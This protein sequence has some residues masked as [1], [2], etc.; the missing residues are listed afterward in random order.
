MV[1]HLSVDMY[2]AFIAGDL[3][4]ANRLQREAAD[5][6]MKL[7]AQPSGPAA[8]KAA[9]EKMGLCDRTMAPPFVE[10]TD[11][12]AGIVWDR[13]KSYCRVPAGAA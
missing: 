8:A 9:L 1:P 11:E 7:P 13:I 2:E 5:F 10:A 4:T 12:E 3:A 6:L